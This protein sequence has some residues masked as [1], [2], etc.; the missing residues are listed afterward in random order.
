MKRLKDQ[1]VHGSGFYRLH[2][3]LSHEE[4]ERFERFGVKGGM[5][6]ATIGSPVGSVMAVPTEERRPPKKGEWYLSGALVE[7]YRAPNDL[8]TAFRIARLVMTETIT[9]VREIA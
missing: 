6:H 7:A 1:G 5:C 3:S 4:C 9:T 8:G 2:D